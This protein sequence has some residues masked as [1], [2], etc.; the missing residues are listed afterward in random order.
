M[1]L[2]QESIQH[3]H[4][5]LQ[6]FHLVDFAALDAATCGDDFQELSKAYIIYLIVHSVQMQSPT[7]H[8]QW[9]S[10]HACTGHSTSISVFS[11]F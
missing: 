5:S 3:S 2:L 7:A 9:E 6:A 10:E 1:I 4:R 8:S 11:C